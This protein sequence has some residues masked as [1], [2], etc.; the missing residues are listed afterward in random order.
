MCNSMSCLLHSIQTLERTNIDLLSWIMEESSMSVC[1]FLSITG[2][3]FVS[4]FD[5]AYCWSKDLRDD[6]NYQL[7]HSTL[8]EAHN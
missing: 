7:A 8:A 3:P 2:E 4:K 1:V 5:L 6:L